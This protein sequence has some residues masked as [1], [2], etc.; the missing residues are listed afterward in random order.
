LKQNQKILSKKEKKKSKQ[1]SK[2]KL[3]GSVTFYD[4]RPGTRWTEPTRGG[5]STHKRQALNECLTRYHQCE[6]SVN[7]DRH[8]FILMSNRYNN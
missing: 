6:H 4:T 2:T 1:Q 8:V 5:A 7:Y 3:P